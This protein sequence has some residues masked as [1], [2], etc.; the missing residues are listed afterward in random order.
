MSESGTSGGLLARLVE[1]VK[2]ALGGTPTPEPV[3]APAAAPPAEPAPGWPQRWADKITTANA[4]MQQV[5]A[6]E[7][8]FV[9]TACATP[10]ALV[11]AL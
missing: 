2:G 3:A 11:A 7:H 1:G 10:R 5:R 4:A 8:V 6:G 9:G